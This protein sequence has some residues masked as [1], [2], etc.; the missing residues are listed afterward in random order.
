MWPS[1]NFLANGDTCEGGVLLQEGRLKRE[2]CVLLPSFPLSCGRARLCASGTQSSGF[3]QDTPCALGSGYTQQKR[4]EGEP[5]CLRLSQSRATEAD[6]QQ[7]SQQKR[8]Q[9]KLKLDRSLLG[10]SLLFAAKPNS[11]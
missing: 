2:E 7:P 3:A 8:N 11:K 6:L 10:R 1:D 9:R 4:R 5:W